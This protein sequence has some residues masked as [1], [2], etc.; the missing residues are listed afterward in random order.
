MSRAHNRYLL[1]TSCAQ[2]CHTRMAVSSPALVCWSTFAHRNK[3]IRSASSLFSI[4]FLSRRLLQCMLQMRRLIAQ[5]EFTYGSSTVESSVC[6]HLNM[7][8][9][10]E[11]RSYLPHVV[12]ASPLQNVY[13]LAHCQKLKA[14]LRYFLNNR[15]TTNSGVSFRGPR[16]QCGR[17][18]CYYMVSALVDPVI[19]VIPLVFE[20]LISRCLVWWCRNYCTGIIVL[21]CFHYTPFNPL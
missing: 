1:R 17:A 21:D 13:S 6:F 19:I 5:F 16:L 8:Q 7:A 20:S 9:I 2:F 14:E 18:A 12:L 15:N 10:V 3:V 4:L 11:D